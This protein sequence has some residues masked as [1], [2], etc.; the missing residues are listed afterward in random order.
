MREGNYRKLWSQV[1]SARKPLLSTSRMCDE[2]NRA[3]FENTGRF[4][5]QLFMGER[6]RSNT[7]DEVHN[8]PST[9]PSHNMDG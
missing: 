9:P 3:V 1:T 8:T 6:A 7:T 5:V 4:A 2:N